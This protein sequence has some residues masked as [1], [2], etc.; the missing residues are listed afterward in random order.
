MLC[1]TFLQLYHEIVVPPSKPNN[2]SLIDM[3][4]NCIQ[5]QWNA[6]TEGGSPIYSYYEVL[7]VSNRG[8]GAINQTSETFMNYTVLELDR[9]YEFTVV[10]VSKAGDVVGRSLQ[11]DPILFTGLLTKYI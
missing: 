6:P 11:S 2:L 1:K 3:K 5:L 7:F 8:D 10:A 4:S 9:P